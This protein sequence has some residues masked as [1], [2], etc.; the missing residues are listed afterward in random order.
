MLKLII[1]IGLI[2]LEVFTTIM[3]G[4]LHENVLKLRVSLLR[5][6]AALGDVRAQCNLGNAYMKGE[7]IGQDKEEAV[8]CWRRKE[9]T[10]DRERQIGNAI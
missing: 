3:S 4:C 9:S 10:N 8:K 5:F 1:L 2:L 7:G 6:D